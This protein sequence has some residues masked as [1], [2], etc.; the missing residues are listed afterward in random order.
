MNVINRVTFA[1]SLALGAIAVLPILIQSYTG[2]STF[3]I[4]GAS[5][6]IVVTVVIESMKQ[7]QSHVTMREYDVY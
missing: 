1:G 7:I 4:G 5:L 2:T 3:A 6:L